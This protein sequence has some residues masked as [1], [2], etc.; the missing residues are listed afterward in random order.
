MQ[1]DTATQVNLTY[2]HRQTNMMQSAKAEYAEL[3]PLH[4]LIAFMQP[5]HKQQA[6][7]V[8]RINGSAMAKIPFYVVWAL[9][10]HRLLRGATTIC[11]ATLS[12]LP[13]SSLI[14]PS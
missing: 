14:L 8:R 10:A 7:E 13:W 2:A 3:H 4:R 12:P 5:V 11:R 9:L 6:V 1:T